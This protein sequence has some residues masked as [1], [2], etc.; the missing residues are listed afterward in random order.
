MREIYTTL[1][2]LAFWLQLSPSL[3][4]Y[5]NTSF[6]TCQEF[7]WISSRRELNSHKR[8]HFLS[9]QGARQRR[10]KGLEPWDVVPWTFSPYRRHLLCFI[11]LLYHTLWSLSRGF[12]NFFFVERWLLQRELKD[13]RCF[14]GHPLGPSVSNFAVYYNASLLTL[15]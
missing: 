12:S 7:F 1:M 6:M 9:Y 15:L 13:G 8:T 11:Y 14:N 5:Y 3:Y 10:E 4:L 2:G